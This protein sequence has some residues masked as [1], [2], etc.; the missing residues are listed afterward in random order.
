M[1]KATKVVS[2][3]VFDHLKDGSPVEWPLEYP[4]T[5]HL[6]KT[7]IGNS[8]GGS[9]IKDESPINKV[10]RPTTRCNVILRDEKGRFVSFR[11]MAKR[12]KLK[13]AIAALPA[14]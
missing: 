2:L 1:A 7:E 4:Y 12:P 11:N 14:Q 8:G 3:Q 9:F 10:F 13:A 6:C 5:V